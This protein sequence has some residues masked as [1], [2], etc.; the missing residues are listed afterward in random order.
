MAQKKTHVENVHHAHHP[1]TSTNKKNIA[2]VQSLLEDDNH[3]TIAEIAVKIGISFGSAQS[4]ITANQGFQKISICCMP[5]LLTEQQKQQC[6]E[7][8]QRLFQCL[9]GK[10]NDVLQHII[11][12]DET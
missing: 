3:L 7:I 12:C 10:G 6:L 4:I 11:T 1:Q 9:Q 2:T 5:C 8:C